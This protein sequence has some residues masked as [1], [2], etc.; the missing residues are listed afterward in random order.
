MPVNKRI[1]SRNPE[2]RVKRRNIYTMGEKLVSTILMAINEKPQNRT[3]NISAS[4]VVF[5][6]SIMSSF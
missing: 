1:T 6:L 4:M 3:V 2:A 5:L